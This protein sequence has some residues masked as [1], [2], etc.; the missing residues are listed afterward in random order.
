MIV[1]YV[2][3]SLRSPPSCP[4]QHASKKTL[5]QFGRPLQ[6]IRQ[7]HC[8]IL[9][10]TERTA[11]KRSCAVPLGMS[12]ARRLLK[13]YGRR[14]VQLTR[15]TAGLF[16]ISPGHPLVS[17]FPP[18]VV[19][20]QEQRPDAR[21]AGEGI[22][23]FKN[24]VH[25][26]CLLSVGAARTRTSLSYYILPNICSYFKESFKPSDASDVISTLDA[27]MPTVRTP[28]TRKAEARHYPDLRFYRSCIRPPSRRPAARGTPPRS[29][30]A[31]CGSP[32]LRTHPLL[33]W[34]RSHTRIR[35]PPTHRPPS[36]RPRGPRRACGA[37]RPLCLPDWPSPR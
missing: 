10:R 18:S 3:H 35:N 17:I 22:Q 2:V 27:R 6:T 9:D 19:Q 26:R 37:L 8:A 11:A 7:N 15:E 33:Q 34:C 20:L 23:D 16:H 36:C 13:G 29:A 31:R 24:Y 5:R 12:E 28:I 32:A 21:H 14:K 30:N 25:G 4:W 1:Q